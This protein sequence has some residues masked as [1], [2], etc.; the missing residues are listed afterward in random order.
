M[1]KRTQEHLEKLLEHADMR[2]RLGAQFDL[3]D[4]G[5]VASLAWIAEHGANA[6]ARRHAMWGLAQLNGQPNS[7]AFA[8]LLQ[9]TSDKDDEIRAQA[10]KGLAGTGG[11]TTGGL[12]AAA[13]AGRRGLEDKAPRVRYFAAQ[14]AAR[15]RNPALLPDVAA[16]LRDN[17]DRDPYLRHAGVVAMMAI[18]DLNPAA[19][20]PAVNDASPSVRLAALLA[21]RRL[22]HPEIAQF[23]NDKEPR[24]QAEA[25]RAIYDV[26]IADAMAH[27][28]ALSPKAPSLSKTL[29]E[30][31][32]EPLLLR[33]IA[34][35]RYLGRKDNA[36]ALAAL[37]ANRDAPTN[38]R[39]E[40]L[41]HLS[42][43]EKPSGRDPIVGLWRPLRDRPKED[44]ADALKTAL[45]ALLTGGFRVRFEAVRLASEHGIKDVG[46]A[47][48]AMVRDG[49]FTPAVRV[50]ALQALQKLGDSEY[51]TIAGL[52]LKSK[53]PRLRQGARALVLPKTPPEDAARQLAEVF[54]SGTTF[55]KQ[56]SFALLADLKSASADALLEQWLDRL[57][58][59]KVPAEVQLDLLEAATRRD[60]PA[61]KKKLAAYDESMPKTDAVLPYRAALAGGDA[62]RG[63][64]LYVNKT[65]L[66]CV[67]CH[68]L[69]G[70]GGEVGPDLTGIGKKFPRQY[71]LEALVD[72]NRQIA[73]GYDTVV[74]N[75]ANGQVKS[76]ILKTEDDKE[77]RLMNADGQMFAVPKA[78]IDERSRGRS[79]MPDDLIKKMTRSELRDLVEFLAGS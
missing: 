29:P 12:E 63:R 53:E 46:P 71:L 42:E 45:P 38:L 9:R 72:P 16:M 24:L 6:G 57:I 2:V 74:L 47:L 8:A 70:N 75:L 43:W 67:R 33:V 23:L 22:Q 28:A 66:S 15:L 50:E 19:L 31:F 69:D 61:L 59:N 73:K 55:E 25:A 13:T 62:E 18:T 14:L 30:A 78:D 60:T 52:A 64:N 58:Q 68:K 5:C 56:G 40:A 32:S 27:L 20:K 21:M 76:G 34:A 1:A 36:A 17:A 37:A 7:D 65:E 48:R 79:A 26:P 3:V 41:K 49:S 35:H 10:F 77:V 54:D 11:C 39:L 51:E 4:R 44:V